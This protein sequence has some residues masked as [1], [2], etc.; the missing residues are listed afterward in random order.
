MSVS[1]TS[2]TELLGP[3]IENERAYKIIYNFN[4]SI[5]FQ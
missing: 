4:I 5:V 3:T 1:N 2:A